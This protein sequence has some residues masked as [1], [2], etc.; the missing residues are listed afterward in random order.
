[1]SKRESQAMLSKL[2]PYVKSA[3]QRLALFTVALILALMPIEYDSVHLHV[4]SDSI[5]P[6]VTLPW[7]ASGNVSSG[8]YSYTSRP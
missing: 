4:E 8:M 5:V 7:S 3:K 6:T 2:V 1:M